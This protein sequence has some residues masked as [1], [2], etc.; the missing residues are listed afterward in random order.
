MSRF[1]LAETSEVAFT[2]PVI[3]PSPP[4]APTPTFEVPRT[5]PPR[6]L[7]KLPPPKTQNELK[8]TLLSVMALATFSVTE[9]VPSGVV[10]RTP[11]FEPVTDAALIVA[12]LEFLPR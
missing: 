10:A 7:E 5:L 2:V 12:V 3:A 4:Q 9:L 8:N 1:E 11:K 6:V